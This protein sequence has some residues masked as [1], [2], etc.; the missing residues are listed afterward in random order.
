MRYLLVIAILV[1]GTIARSQERIE[2]FAAEVAFKK[3]KEGEWKW[4]KRRDCKI[5]FTISG[6]VIIA[7]D[8]AR[9][10]YYSY[11]AM[12][13]DAYNIIHNAY[14]NQGNFCTIIIEYR[15]TYNQLTIEY[16]NACYKYLFNN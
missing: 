1:I 9:S 15:Y 3:N 16:T 5:V 4:K 12:S 8:K 6:D 10:R 14:D 13:Y 11:N 2:S 7:S